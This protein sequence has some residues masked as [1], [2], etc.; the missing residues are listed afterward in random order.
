MKILQIS[1][2]HLS[3]VA[4]LPWEIQKSHFQQYYRDLTSDYIL[5]LEI[6]RV[7]RIDST[8]LKID[9]LDRLHRLASHVYRPIHFSLR[10]FS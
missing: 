1:S 3:A 8:R 6:D 10:N 2:P 7:E 5:D 9:R 4:T